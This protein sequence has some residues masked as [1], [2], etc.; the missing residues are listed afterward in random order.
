M[1]KKTFLIFLCVLFIFSMGNIVVS[2]SNT[3]QEAYN[4]AVSA[5]GKIFD[6]Y[7]KYLNYED[8]VT[9][10][11][12]LSAAADYIPFSNNFKTIYNGL[13]DDDK[14]LYRD[15]YEDIL[16]IDS[17]VTDPI[18]HFYVFISNINQMYY[19]LWGLPDEYDDY[20]VFDIISAKQYM[21]F[22]DELMTEFRQFEW[23]FFE[24]YAGGNIL[25]QVMQKFDDISKAAGQEV[26]QSVHDFMEVYALFK[27]DR[28][29]FYDLYDMLLYHDLSDE[30]FNKTKT[31]LLEAKNAAAFSFDL[32]GKAY[33]KLPADVKET[34]YV[35]YIMY[36]ANYYMEKINSID[37][38]YIDTLVLFIKE[39]I[40]LQNAYYEYYELYYELRGNDFSDIEFE[41]IK[42]ELLTIKT[43][44]INAQTSMKQIYNSLSE[45][46][47]ED[48]EFLYRINNADDY[49]REISETERLVN[50]TLFK[51][52]KEINRLIETLPYKYEYETEYDYW[53]HNGKWHEYKHEYISEFSDF[54]Y[55][56]FTK[57]DYQNAARL[58]SLYNS[59]SNANKNLIWS[60]KNFSFDNLKEAARG[61][62]NGDGAVNGMDLLFLKQQILGMKSLAGRAL[63]QCDLN[64][65]GK[66]N[67]MD[68]LIL[69]KRILA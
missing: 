47:K 27:N 33:Q 4:N 38:V 10:E 64:Y 21:F 31:E 25:S 62:I 22:Y 12:V 54:D 65:D 20:T 2:A 32:L 9:E 5:Y 55:A 40:K 66:I 19:I 48:W 26:P 18:S 37:N 6:T 36:N 14:N 63:V 16:H 24:F 15:C 45:G 52:L 67:G 28:Y 57:E 34:E 56:S 1:I 41:K 59:L 7:V 69:K 42:K 51:T 23:D 29:A 30:D 13:S 61:D 39:Y 58:F 68:L 11:D 17:F 3:L 49:I 43:D 50:S 44:L 53:Y 8:Y 60:E 46:N 35:E